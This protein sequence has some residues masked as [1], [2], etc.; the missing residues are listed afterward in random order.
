MSN[1]AEKGQQKKNNSWT[2]EVISEERG[3]KIQEKSDSERY[4]QQEKNRGRWS[5][6]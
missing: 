2:Q 4:R 6:N 1:K 3:Q 5:E